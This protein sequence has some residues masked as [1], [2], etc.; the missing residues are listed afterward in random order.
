MVKL[1]DYYKLLSA[2]PDSVLGCA[3]N[4]AKDLKTKYHS[5]VVGSGWR[6][7]PKMLLLAIAWMVLTGIDL[8]RHD[9]DYHE[10]MDDVLA[11]MLNK[12][13]SS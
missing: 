8:I 1:S 11:E 9:P 13:M 5:V 7:V 3:K 4:N 12:T 2:S 6:A 10:D